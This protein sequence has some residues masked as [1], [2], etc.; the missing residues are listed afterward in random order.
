MTAGLL[1]LICFARP[2]AA[3]VTALAVG[4][5]ALYSGL[6]GR[7]LDSVGP[8][9]TMLGVDPSSLSAAI[10]RLCRRLMWPCVIT[11]PLLWWLGLWGG[12]GLLVGVM[13]AWALTA[14]LDAK[15]ARV[16]QALALATVLCCVVWS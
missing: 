10:T 4:A 12:V 2:S 16:G 7:G 9:L 5:V 1:C 8:S 6:R 3:G 14:Q 13:T 11:L 15:K